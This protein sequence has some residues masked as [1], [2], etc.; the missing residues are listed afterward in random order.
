MTRPNV[1][2]DKW[3]CPHTDRTVVFL[4][5]DRTEVAGTPIVLADFKRYMGQAGT[6]AV[7]M[8]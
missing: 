6:C 2:L 4:E 8:Q 7:F 3:A 5:V 1:P